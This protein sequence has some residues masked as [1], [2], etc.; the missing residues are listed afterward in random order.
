M[1]A[2][3]ARLINRTLTGLTIG[4]LLAAAS[5]PVAKADGYLTNAEIAYVAMYHDAICST[6][7]SYPSYAG[8]MGIA[9]VI[10]DDD[11]FA[12]HDVADIINSAVENHCY[13]HWGL[14]VAIGKNARG[15][16][17][18]YKI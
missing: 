17:A 18:G 4:A 9:Q 6:L 8:V 12:F 3:R 15:Q 1:R 10:H 11:G 7:D 13:R 14:L 2:R 5:M 16:S